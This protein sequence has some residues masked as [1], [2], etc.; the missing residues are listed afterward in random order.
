MIINK[1][2]SLVF[3]IWVS[4]P[5]ASDIVRDVNT[6]SESTH[7]DNFLELGLSLDTRS[8]HV[9]SEWEKGEEIE[10]NLLFSG[11]FNYRG[12]FI[13]AVR[14]SYDGLNLGYQFVA[15]PNW[16]LDLLAPSLE[17]FSEVETDIDL[18]AFDGRRFKNTNYVGTGIRAT[19][20]FDKYVVQTRLVTDVSDGNGEK[21]TIRV[22]RSWQ[23]HNFD[24]HALAGMEYTSAKTNQYFY[25][26]TPDEANEVYPAYSPG[27]GSDFSLEL[28]LTYPLS[29]HVVW[30]AKSTLETLSDAA[31]DSAFYSHDHE[32]SAI[33][34][35]SYV[36]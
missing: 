35:I 27:G 20:Y 26:I 32:L 14:G 9:R 33:T 6:D 12:F 17:S 15:A 4:S 19:A 22:G 30:R 31:K 16:S 3:I 13:E 23:L 2:I 29:E 10:L 21:A 28:G 1:Y 5:Y 36:F 7:T 34:S 18:G 24:L 8:Y 25:G 11:A